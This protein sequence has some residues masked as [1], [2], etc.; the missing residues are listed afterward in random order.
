ML[1]L[2]GWCCLREDFRKFRIDR[3]AEIRPTDESFRPRRV[4]MLREFIA[5]MNAGATDTAP[6]HLMG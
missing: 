6:A 2:L 5:R 3:I 1:V 4:P